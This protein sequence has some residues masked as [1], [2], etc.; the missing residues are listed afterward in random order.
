MRNRREQFARRRRRR[1]RLH[2]L[3]MQIWP[4]AYMNAM[5]QLAKRE[6]Y[7]TFFL[8]FLYKDQRRQK[9][10]KRENQKIYE[11]DEEKFGSSSF[12]WIK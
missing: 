1:C 9:P 8:L 11:Y 2:V 3:I 5:T 7:R 6:S 12:S 10:R 4:T